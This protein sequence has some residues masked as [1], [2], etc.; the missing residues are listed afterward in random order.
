MMFELALIVYFHLLLK[1]FNKL[2]P[3]DVKLGLL[4]DIVGEDLDGADKV[5][6][7]LLDRADSETRE[8]QAKEIIFVDLGLL[9]NPVPGDL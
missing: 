8:S 3:L 1:I 5:A 7:M 2:L 6:V 4:A 9:G